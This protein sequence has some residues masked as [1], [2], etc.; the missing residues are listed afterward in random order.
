MTD[1]IKNENSKDRI[2]LGNTRFQ[3]AV[4][5][6]VS[7]MMFNDGMENGWLSPVTKILTSEMSPTGSALTSNELI[8]VGST[9]AFTALCLVSFFAYISDAYGRKAG[10]LAVGIPQ[11]MNWAIKLFATNTTLL[12][13][14]RAVAGI[15][16]AGCFIALPIYVREISQD[17]IRGSTVSLLILMQN[18]GF[19]FMYIMGS[20]LNYYTILWISLSAATLSTVLMLFA[21]ES[22]PYLVKKEKLDEAVKTL[23]KLRGLQADHKIIQLEVSDMKDEEQYYKSLPYLTFVNIFKN[24]AWRR[25]FLRVILINTSQSGSGTF[26]IMTYVWVILS[27]SGVS[28]DPNLQSLVVPVLLLFGSVV[29]MVLV[30]KFGRKVNIFFCT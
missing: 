2:R 24:K 13:F 8:W 4:V 21:P 19:L 5:M 20:Y 27:S 30:R 1:K 26:A 15:A 10:V 14:S 9:L 6:S 29:S 3:W 17:S 22:P 12:I 16:S 25:G 11:L 18:V 23:A 7:L 28:F